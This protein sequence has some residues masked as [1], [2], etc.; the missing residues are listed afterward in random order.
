MYK[1]IFN[2]VDLIIFDMD[3]TLYEGREH[4]KLHV[5][6]LLEKLPSDKQ[7]Q[8]MDIYNRVLEGHHPLQ[9]GKIYDG[10]RDLFWSWDPFEEKLIEARN[11]DDEVVQVEDAPTHMAAQDF[12]FVNW[13]PVGDGWW[14]PYAIARHFGLNVAE[15]QESYNLTKVQMAEQD[16]YLQQ[17]PG[18]KEYLKELKADKKLIVC[19]NSDEEDAKRLLKFLEIDDCFDE[20]IPSALKP[21]MTK[22]YFQEVLESYQVDASR[23][24]SVGD[25]YMNE[26]APALQLGMYAVW[27]TDV[28]EKPVDDERL[29][30]TETLAQV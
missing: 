19:T 15:I 23:A 29:I 16:G 14:P 13:V 27:L 12:D 8:F 10:A 17:T 7:K 24:V 3:G 26:I 30:L 9:I 22:K 25:N 11:W 2:D 4:F 21:V 18:L 5:N 20:L 28:T 1:G 6:N